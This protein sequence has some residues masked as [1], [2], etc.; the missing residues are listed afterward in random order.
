MKTLLAAVVFFTVFTLTLFTTP[1]SHAR[2]AIF[3]NAGFP[4]AVVVT[5]RGFNNGF[6]CMNGFCNGTCWNGWNGGFVQP[7]FFPPVFSTPVTAYPLIV[8]T[9]AVVDNI[10]GPGASA[11]RRMAPIRNSNIY[12]GW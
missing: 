10:Y 5:S 9:T 1:A 11:A 4:G 8:D 2:G 7:G 12:H 6:G 3:V